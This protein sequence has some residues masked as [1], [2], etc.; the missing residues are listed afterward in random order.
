MTIET[1]NEDRFSGINPD[2]LDPALKQL[3]KSMQADYTRKRQEDAD[4]KKAAEDRATQLE[5]EHTKLV[6][7]YN[8]TREYTGQLE[9]ANVKWQQWFDSNQSSDE[10][11]GDENANNQDGDGNM[12]AN[13]NASPDSGNA[14]VNLDVD[15]RIAA[16]TSRYDKGI[17]ELSNNQAKLEK[18]LG[19]SLQLSE[20]EKEHGSDFEI[21]R[22]RIVKTAIDMGT[23]DL[24]AAF[25]TAYQPE[26]IQKKVDAGV[27]EKLKETEEANKQSI[28]DGAGRAAEP[29]Y[30][31]RPEN[32]P[33][34]YPEATKQIAQELAAKGESLIT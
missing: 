11:G 18:Q 17:Q 28:I 10:D 1:P 14:N 27:A 19:F 7:Q 4:S 20:I 5:E 13:A 32:A 34:T 9:E 30:Y 3:Y 23:D 31:T 12:N 15:A 33:R 8:A 6:E 29:T 22:Q 26:I 24:S 25:Q 2:E 16:V 21:D